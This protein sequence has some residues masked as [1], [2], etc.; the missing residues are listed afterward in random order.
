MHATAHKF[1]NIAIALGLALLAI[2]L[3]TFYVTNYK[4]HVQNGEQ[5]VNMLVA[6]KDIPAGTA[7]NDVIAGNMLTTRSVARREVVPGAISG[8]AQLRG[9]ISNQVVYAGEQV[10]ARRFGTPAQR[11][12]RSLLTGTDRAYQLA[13]D[14]NQLLGGTLR[15]GDRVDVVATW[16]YPEGG[17]A[18]VSRV[19]LRNLLVLTPPASGNVQAKIGTSVNDLLSAQLAVSDSQS[20]KLEWAAENAK[21]HLELRPPQKSADSPGGVETSGTLLVDGVSPGVLRT[22]LTAGGPR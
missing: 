6:S 18:H 12:I 5:T 17:Q 1:W 10:T 13:G 2:T 14:Q 3:T 7:G 22:R 20:Q 4:R 19:I 16:T 15:A 8:T 21:W 11:G 9:L